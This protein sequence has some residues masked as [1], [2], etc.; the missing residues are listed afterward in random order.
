MERYGRCLKKVTEQR[1]YNMG[2][3]LDGTPCK[4]EGTDKEEKGRIKLKNEKGRRVKF[5]SGQGKGRQRFEVVD[6]V[7]R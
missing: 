2:S 4:R 3:C 7:E 1:K 5:K 6:G